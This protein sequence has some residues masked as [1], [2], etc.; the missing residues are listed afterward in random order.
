LENS[1]IKWNTTKIS[2][3]S[4]IVEFTYSITLSINKQYHKICEFLHW[5]HK[6]KSSKYCCIYI[7]SSSKHCCVYIHSDVVVITYIV[8]LWE[9]N[10]VILYDTTDF[11]EFLY[12]RKNKKV[13]K[14]S[15][16]VYISYSTLSINKQ[17]HWLWGIPGFDP[18]KRILK[19]TAVVVFT[20]G[21]MLRITLSI[22]IKKNVRYHWLWK[23][24]LRFILLYLGIPQSRWC[25]L[26]IVLHKELHW[27]STYDTTDFGEFLYKMKHKANLQSQRYSAHG[28]FQTLNIAIFGSTGY[29]GRYFEWLELRLFMNEKFPS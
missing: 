8:S 3:V 19:V 11:G 5:I 18:K 21:I 12:K 6:K 22:N 24:C 4:A 17:H 1:Y 28:G 9:W 20:Y 13:S 14:V 15:T 29:R 2:K 16:F 23:C 26:L 7:D 25:R 27:V 10:W